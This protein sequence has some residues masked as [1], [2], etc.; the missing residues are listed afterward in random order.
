MEETDYIEY[1]GEF[2]LAFMA[3][4]LSYFITPEN[5][6]TLV[7]LLS[8]PV[9]FGFTAYISRDGFRKSSLL[10]L[11]ALVFGLL[12]TINALVAVF[13]AVGNILVS[14]FAGGE[15]FRD[16]Y[17]TTSL[18]VLL[19]GLLIGLLVFAAI[20]TQPSTSDNLKQTAA[21]TL[22]EQTETLVKSSGL[23]ESQK[24]A[25]VNAMESVSTA[26]VIATKGV[27]LNETGRT[28]RELINAFET[29]QKEVPE[30]ISERSMK[31]LDNRS[32]DISETVERST[33]ELISD[34]VFL[35]VIPGAAFF[36]YS[37]QPLIGFLTALFAFGFK[38]ADSNRQS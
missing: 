27:V 1:V 2:C 22:G 32:V 15:R 4:A 11:A 9:L 38:K 31:Q 8:I 18:P 33:R 7:I 17:S 12:G 19:T 13:V 30:K 36:L 25:Q 37:L 14:V 21:K 3:A 34:K 26:T 20:S 29:A 10:S 6:A 24:Q 35:A 23:I 5:P 28:D 16:F